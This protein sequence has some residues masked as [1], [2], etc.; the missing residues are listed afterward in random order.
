MKY[1][2]AFFMGLIVQIF[3]FMCFFFVPFALPF[4]KWDDAPTPGGDGFSDPVIRGDIGLGFWGRWL[5]TPDERLPGGLYEKTVRRVYDRFGAVFCSWYWLALRNRGFGFARAL[6]RSS[7]DYLPD[8]PDGYF[9]NSDGVWRWSKSLGLFRF[10]IGWQVY[11]ALDK[12]FYAVPVFSLK[13]I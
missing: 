13:K 1:L 2:Y 3:G 5:S 12:T 9:E 6:S 11:K 7:V 10:V 8:L 4:I